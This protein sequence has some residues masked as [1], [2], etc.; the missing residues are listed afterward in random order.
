MINF[1]Y[2]NV[3]Q[4]YTNGIYLK[5]NFKRTIFIQVYENQKLTYIYLKLIIKVNQDTFLCLKKLH[6]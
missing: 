5:Y 2:I 3:L 4:T 6:F 1:L